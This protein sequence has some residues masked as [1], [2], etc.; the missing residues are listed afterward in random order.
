MAGAVAYD[1]LNVS[2]ESD[3]FRA[4]STVAGKEVQAVKE[5]R[6]IW[7][8]HNVSGGSQGQPVDVRPLKHA[9]T[10]QGYVGA[11]IWYQRLGA[12]KGITSHSGS[13]RGGK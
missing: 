8:N 6:A 7:V 5:V 11:R 13:I 12:A 1:S 4:D 10:E 3:G 2:A 9:V